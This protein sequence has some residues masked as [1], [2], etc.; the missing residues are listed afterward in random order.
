M[1]SALLSKY[2][3]NK[4]ESIWE[5]IP[6]VPSLERFRAVLAPAIAN[7]L[8]GGLRDRVEGAWLALGGPACVESETDLEDAAIYLDEL[9]RL[10]EAGGLSD[11][12]LLEAKLEKLWALP[13]VNAGPGSVELMTIHK[14]KGLE[15][16]TVIVPGL[17]RAPRSS[18]RQL[19]AWKQLAASKLML[20][21][22][23]EAGS[24]KEPLYEYVRSLEKTAEDVEAGRLFY[25]AATRARHRLH[26]LGCAKADEA[27]A[28]KPPNKRSLLAKAWFEAEGFFPAQVL[29]SE[30]KPPHSLPP[31]MLRRLPSTYAVPAPPSAAKWNAPPEGRADEE[32]IAFDWAQ[33]PARLA[34]VVVHGWLQRLAEDGL[35]GWDAARVETLKP[36]V[37]KELNRLGVPPEGM[38]SAAGSVVAALKNAL[39]DERGRWILGKHP[40][41]RSELRLC[42]AAG[43]RMR[44]DRYIEDAKGQRWVVDFKTGE[45][46]G[47]NPEA[48][49]DDQ[50]KRYAR[51]LDA[52]AEAKGGARRALYFP[53]LKGWRQW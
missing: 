37:I 42:T 33:E 52:Y 45:H 34:G 14:A 22:I 49:L 10:E 36:R 17:D 16:D 13:D 50:K 26:L 53:L 3:E 41:A 28:L 2:F 23:N 39:A 40:F 25:V 38:E 5:L 11:L 6:K 35:Q 21:P 9:E 29:N 15:W 19:F 31:Q 4:N 1:T 46:Q 12:A 32:Q 20:A 43:K 18:E 44:I 24:D 27:G 51:Q 30:Q 8:R 7:R 47:G 48:Y